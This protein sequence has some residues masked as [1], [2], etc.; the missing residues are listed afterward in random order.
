MH[1][2]FKKK[3]K[4]SNKDAADSKLVNKTYAYSELAR[5]LKGKL[6]YFE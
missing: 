5:V 3:E 6:I 4:D 1:K 2:L